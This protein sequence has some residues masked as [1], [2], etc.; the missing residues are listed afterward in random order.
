MAYSQLAI[1]PGPR[2]VFAHYIFYI[3]ILDGWLTLVSGAAYS[4]RW[5]VG[6]NVKIPNTI[7]NKFIVKRI[8]QAVIKKALG[9][10]EYLVWGV[11]F[12]PLNNPAAVA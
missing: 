5:S 12:N 9:V 4:E 6:L 2:L 7:S 1:I 10:K 8:M 3:Y 11:R